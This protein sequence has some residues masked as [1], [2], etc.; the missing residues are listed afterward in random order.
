MII[1][2]SI[3]LMNPMNPNESNESKFC[4]PNESDAVFDIQ[5]KA[6]VY[7]WMVHSHK[8]GPVWN[9]YDFTHAYECI[10]AAYHRT[11]Y[12]VSALVCIFYYLILF[13]FLFT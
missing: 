10:V 4:A 9:K 11:S 6:F 1:I 12:N 8:S 5:P 7:I 13:L 3:L 2:G